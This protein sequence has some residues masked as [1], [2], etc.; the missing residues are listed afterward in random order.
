MS[1]SKAPPPPISFDEFSQL[2][3]EAGIQVA[4][5]EWM[6]YD[7][8]QGVAIADVTDALIEITEDPHLRKE[9]VTLDSIALGLANLHGS[10]ASQ[11]TGQV[12]EAAIALAATVLRY[13]A[14][15][16]DESD[17]S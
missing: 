10:H 7:F 13:V 6:E 15:N 9:E 1:L 17:V 14:A 4:D 11:D 12:R 8:R 3:E 16:H 2:C 5:K